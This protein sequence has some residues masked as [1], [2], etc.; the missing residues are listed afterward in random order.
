MAESFDV[1]YR[2]ACERKGG[3]AAVEARL[4][5]PLSPKAI[6]AIPDDRFLAAMTKKVFQS[7]FVWRVIE[8]KWPAFEEVFFGFD[9]EKVLLMPD[10][11]LEQKASDKRI[12]RNYKKVMTVRDNALFISDITREYGSFGKYVSQFGAHNITEL[13]T[14]LKKRGARLGG[15]TGPYM[16]RAIGVDTFLLSRDVEDYLRKHD[17]VT[18]GTTS[19]SSLKAMNA[20]FATW[21]E[22][23]N[24]PLSQISQILALSWGD[25]QR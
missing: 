17:V 10:E 12:V 15:N 7:G 13:W 23:S 2:R 16:L 18:G 3:P 9:I 20:Q 11:M 6:Q 22:Q 4:G 5:S 21:H 14:A 8:Q 1:I 19:L 25:N 24:R